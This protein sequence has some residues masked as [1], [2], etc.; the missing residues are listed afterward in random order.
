VSTRSAASLRTA[1]AVLALAAL[2]GGCNRILAPK[3]VGS[4]V[5]ASVTRTVAAFDK[6]KIT[7]TSPL[8]YRPGPGYKV[9]LEGDDNLLPL[10]ESNV[11]G[12]ILHLGFTG[13][14]HELKSPFHV[15][16]EAPT[17]AALES[18]GS[19]DAELEQVR[20]ESFTLDSSG[21]A[22][23]RATGEVANLR[24]ESAGMM[25]AQVYDLKARHVFVDASGSADVRVTAE[26]TIGVDIKGSG[27][28]RYRGKPQVTE[29][30]VAGAGKI[31]P[32]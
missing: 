4:G 21:V 26:E 25:D 32:E 28:V 13:G 23:V 20:G 9:V 7:G 15:S 27:T 17:L 2:V 18:A 24:I 3:V 8:H 16:I 29:N 1:C 22:K 14:I 11:S 6:V 30:R 5:S 31:V 19:L 10:Y 12:G